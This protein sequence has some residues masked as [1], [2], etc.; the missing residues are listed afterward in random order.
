MKYKTEYEQ[1]LEDMGNKLLD[2]TKKVVD[3]VN[4]ISGTY[5]DKK[6]SVT[7]A[8]DEYH[9]VTGRLL[10]PT[11]EAKDC[12]EEIIKDG[13]KETKVELPEYFTEEKLLQDVANT[14]KE[15]AEANERIKKLREILNSPSDGSIP[16][17]DTINPEDN[18]VMSFVDEPDKEDNAENINLI[19]IAINGIRD[20]KLSIDDL[21]NRSKDFMP[22]ASDQTIMDLLE[23][24]KRY[25]AGEKFNIYSA[26]PKPIQIM[27][28]MNAG[29]YANNRSMLNSAANLLM[30]QFC[31][32][33]LDAAMGQEII[34]FNYAI[35][36]ALDIPSIV[37]MYEGY[38]RDRF[39]TELI[40]KADKL[41][42]EGFEAGAKVLRDCSQAYVDTYTFDRQIK[43]LTG[44]TRRKLYKDNSDYSRYVG[45]FNTRIAK[46]PYKTR[47]VHEMT[48]AL[49]QLKPFTG[50]D[51]D[52]I[53]AFVI[54]FIKTSAFLDANNTADAMFMCYSI[55]NITNMSHH[56]FIE[57]YTVA[58]KVFDKKIPEFDQL[59]INN[60]RKLVDI[61]HQIKE[62]RKSR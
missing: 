57:A 7:D 13:N 59:I 40:N 36:E 17:N 8:I 3:G 29:D 24:A 42:A 21:R 34:D 58:P 54:L 41:E 4:D 47:D 6:P 23:V 27:I 5:E 43:A 55:Q 53:V 1:N 37:E 60:I 18:D 35:K 31:T 32:E 48:K 16:Y 46:T 30:D 38:T 51:D 61:M 25:K 62:E 14:L 19:D 10:D 39:S 22:N 2:L 9:K 15:S 49:T 20:K 26:L 50:M 45:E 28:N 33:V 52:D 12:I 11:K 56:G 44:K